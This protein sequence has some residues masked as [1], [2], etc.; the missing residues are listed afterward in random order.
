MQTKITEHQRIWLPPVN[1]KETSHRWK[2]YKTVKKNT[3]KGKKFDI[4]VQ[5]YNMYMTISRT[6]TSAFLDFTLIDL[7]YS[8][9]A[10]FKVHSLIF[11]LLNLMYSLRLLT[12]IKRNPT[13]H[14]KQSI[15]AKEKQK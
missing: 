2:E 12:H 1:A 3:K 7:T 8:I 14:S 5:Q 11:C 15:L 4:Q 10:N 6:S 9:V 13:Q